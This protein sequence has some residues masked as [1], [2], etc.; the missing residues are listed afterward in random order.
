MGSIKTYSTCCNGA[1]CAVVF[2]DGKEFSC[3]GFD[4]SAAQTSAQAYCMM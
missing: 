2:N 3:N 1:C 4:C